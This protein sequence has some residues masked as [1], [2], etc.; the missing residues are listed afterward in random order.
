M[1]NILYTLL[2][3]LILP[4]CDVLNVDPEDAIPANE[5]FKDKAGIERGILGT[6]S[7]LQSLSYFGRTNIIFA[8]LAADNLVHPPD[9]T[10]SDYAEVD[11]NA[12]L[13]ENG[14]MS[15]LW[16]SL[17]EGINDANNVIVKVPG[18][19]NMSDSEKN[20]ALGELYFIRALNHFNLVNYFGAVP[21]KINPTVGVNAL[22][23]GRDPVE[24]V[25]TSIIADLTFAEQNLQESASTKTRATKYGAKALLARVYLYKG[26]YALAHEKADEVINDGGYTLP[27]EFGDVFAAD[28][29]E[30]TIFEIDFTE[31]DRNR[32]AEYNFPKTLNG[33]REVAPSAE[34]INLFLPDDERK[35]VSIAYDG[36]NAYANKYND[37]SKG[38][39]NVIVLRLGEMYLIR[40]E[41]EAHI[42][43]G[44]ITSIQDDI[45]VIRQRANL[46]PTIAGTIVD[47]LSAIETERR[48]EF[49]FEGQRWFDLIRTGRATEVLPSVTNLNKTLFPIP[50]GELQTNKNPEMFQ[51]PGY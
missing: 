8:D 49:A 11:N 30:E 31:V 46:V 15:A 51:N 34:L 14:A 3:L 47:L 38:A 36:V 41:A 33:R 18:I 4:G 1:K 44:S 42:P 19:P 35:I 21:V 50:S 28:G 12:L 20:Q 22:D 40:A 23:A 32:I 17:Y 13:P 26:E 6:Y 24:E 5:A 2:L 48:L 45:N 10:S 9:A 43:G 39:D 29:S 16:G 25:Y 27:D 7:S 37:L